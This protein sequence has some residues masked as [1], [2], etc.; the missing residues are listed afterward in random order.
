VLPAKTA[1]EAQRQYQASG[2]PLGLSRT[3]QIASRAWRRIPDGERATME[4]RKAVDAAADHGSRELGRALAT[5]AEVRVTSGGWREGAKLADEAIAYGERFA[6]PW[7]LANGFIAKSR[8]IRFASINDAL[9]LMNRG[10]TLAMRAGLNDTVLPGFTG[11]VHLMG[12]LRRPIDQRLALIEEGL[13]YA[14]R[15]GIEE[16]AHLE[17][18]KGS[19]Q[20]SV[21]DWDAALA[22]IALGREL[23]QQYS[24]GLEAMIC[25]GRE[26]PKAA[27]PIALEVGE[28]GARSK[29]SWDF[30]W[31]MPQAATMCLLA[32]EEAAGREWLSRLR[33]T[34]DE[35]P[36]A[37][38]QA[39]ELGGAAFIAATVIAALLADEPWWA[40]EIA[41]GT[42]W[43]TDPAIEL[44]RAEIAATQS[45][46]DGRPEDTPQHLAPL[47]GVGTEVWQAVGAGGPWFTVI[48][49][50]EA[51]RRG[52][53]LD[54]GWRSP[55]ENARK[56]SARAKANWYLEQL[57]AYGGEA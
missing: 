29:F 26:G 1:E 31:S 52:L 25:R 54:A 32:D 40:D 45:I 2:D 16:T 36:D 41:K 47:F 53:S 9:D 37:R 43:R 46:L 23:H 11:T 8:A 50:R 34:L 30:V 48:C 51:A 49:A 7:T 38:A 19:I 6:D 57:D 21:G 20:A 15:R 42:N 56:F 13:E 17:Y 14:R 3:H 18:M 22:T 4:A 55:I 10:R 28:R 33:R 27:L 12:F 5:L 39:L 35:D 24:R 44:H